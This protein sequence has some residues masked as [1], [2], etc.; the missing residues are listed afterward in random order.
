VA[1]DLGP[2]PPPSSVPADDVPAARRPSFPVVFWSSL[3]VLVLAVA[4]GATGVLAVTGASRTAVLAPVGLVA[5]AALVALGCYRFEWF[6]LTVLAVRSTMDATAARP[7]GAKFASTVTKS[8]EAV[9]SGPAATGLAALF[10]VIAVVW[11]LAQRRAAGT[12]RLSAAEGAFAAFVAACLISVLGAV[13]H[14]AALTECARIIAAVLMFV[15]LAR[16]LT[17]LA[18][19]RRCLIAC[20]IGFIAPVLLGLMQVAGRGAD[21]Q[22]GGLSRIIGTFAHPNTFGFFLSMFMLMAIALFRHCSVQVRWALAAG[23]V[24]CGVLLVFT[25]ARGPWIALVLG[26]I[27][28]GILQSRFIFVWLVGAVVLAL[29]VVPSALGRITD[30]GSGNTASGSTSNS[31]SW[32]FEYWQQVS[33][34]NH[35]NPVTGIGLKGT[36]YLTDQNK[37]PHNDLLR[38]Y[39]ETGLLGLLAYVL[40]IIAL[41][42]VARQALRSAP[43]GFARGVAVGFA[44]VLVAYLL[45][46]MTDNLMSEV[47]VLWYFYAAA[48]CAYAVAR[49]GRERVAA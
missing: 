31:L 38:A 8:P 18:A 33:V 39:V 49:L 30:L 37:A 23:T 25:Y 11:L 24:I 48:A 7:T 29:G 22:S 36:K 26:L 9:S 34:L 19:V 17:S 28:I 20:A 21:F 42:A 15:V 32:R 45:D 2:A 41:I 44:A 12:T 35:G 47:V 14:I 3:A 1:I 10:I 4:A 27:L 5:V 43:A 6:V 13:N 40:V 16:L 46:S